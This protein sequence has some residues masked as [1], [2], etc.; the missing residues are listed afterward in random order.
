MGMRNSP[1]NCFITDLPTTNI[2]SAVDCINYAIRIDSEIKQFQFDPRHINNEFVNQNKHI[3]YGLILN[4]FDSLFT[5]SML[6]ND[7]LEK[8]I[9][10]S[11]FPKLPEE[12]IANLLNYLHGQQSFEGSNIELHDPE[13]IATKLYF[14]NREELNFYLLT[15]NKKQLISGVYVQELDFNYNWNNIKLT[16]E[17]LSEV[18]RINESSIQSNRCFVAMSFSQESRPTREIIKETLKECG[19]EPVLIDETHYEAE[20]TINDALIAE[21]KKCKFMVADFTEHKHGVY[22]EAGFALGLKRPVIY[23]CLKSDFENA[24]FDTKHYPHILYTDLNELKSMLKNKIEAW[25]S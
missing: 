19:Y 20:K 24:H 17:G 3:L 10:E 9:Q 7:I 23:L 11:S 18:I 8:I 13:N 5:T 25:I 15:L 12:K 6:N 14:K 21:I 1:T 22:F 16:F 4:N 2:P